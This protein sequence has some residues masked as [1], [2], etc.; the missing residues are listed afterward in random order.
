MTEAQQPDLVFICGPSYRCG[1]TLIQRV[2][3][4]HPEV[5]VYGEDNNI[6]KLGR[7]LYEHS[8]GSA[9]HNEQDKNFKDDPFTWQANLGAVPDIYLQAYARFF[10]EVILSPRRAEQVG[11]D[12]T[13]QQ[14]VGIKTLFNSPLELKFA[15]WL[16]PSCKIIFCAR[17]YKD[18]LRS[19]M[20]QEWSNMHHHDYYHMWSQSMEALDTAHSQI[21]L[22]IDYKTEFNADELT[23]QLQTLLP[24]VT[25][26][27][28]QIR[29]VTETK[30][31]FEENKPIN[32]DPL[33][34][35]TQYA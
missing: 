5:L 7:V 18:C 3:N 26:D 34:I 14:Y 11:R 22:V 33:P 17:A 1:S 9:E 8:L 31:V 4:I 28:E 20:R 10:S 19:Y 24:R 23:E 27:V 30:L 29:K 12:I 15:K 25:L 32:T 6:L 16:L 2:L 35:W 13:K 21:D